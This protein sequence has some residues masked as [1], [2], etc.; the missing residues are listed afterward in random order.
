MRLA[1]ARNACKP[2]HPR[3]GGDD[4]AATQAVDSSLLW[5]PTGASHVVKS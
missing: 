1:T 4:G 5:I 3:E 2:R